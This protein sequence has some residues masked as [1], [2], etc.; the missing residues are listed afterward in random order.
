MKKLRPDLFASLLSS[1]TLI[2]LWQLA[3]WFLGAPIILP[4]PLEVAKELVN[5]ISSTS[6]ASN[7]GFTTLRALESFILI[8]SCGT[9]AGLLAARYFLF[10]KF[11]EPLITVF[12]AT[13]V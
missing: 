10:N 7:L 2:L 13:P 6:F 9:L 8:V 5:L 4:T 11:L 1:L 12:K 3:A